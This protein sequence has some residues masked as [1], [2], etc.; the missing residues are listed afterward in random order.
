MF[1][2]LQVDGEDLSY[3]IEEQLNFDTD[4]IPKALEKQSGLVSWWGHLLSTKQMEYKNF[5]AKVEVELAKLEK[6]IRLDPG[7]ATTYGKVTESV[8]SAEVK[9]HPDYI[10]FQEELNELERQV[11]YLRSMVNGFESRTTILATAGSLRRSEIEAN[12]RSLVNR[13]KESHS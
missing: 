13:T 2:E 9:M 10:R 11:G 4:S 3:N 12:I 5:K 6:S 1:V 8:I 7:L